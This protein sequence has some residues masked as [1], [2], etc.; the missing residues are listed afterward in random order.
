MAMCVIA[1]YGLDSVPRTVQVCERET[2]FSDAT[3]DFGF[4]DPVEDVFTITEVARWDIYRWN[5]EQ[6]V[7][8]TFSVPFDGEVPA[9]W[10]PYCTHVSFKSPGRIDLS[11]PID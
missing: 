2:V 11:L 10:R 9:K 3:D 1:P 7:I 4:S 8:E 5:R 6:K